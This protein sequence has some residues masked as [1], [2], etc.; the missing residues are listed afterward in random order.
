M[1]NLLKDMK[2]ELEKKFKGHTFHP[3]I[4]KENFCGVSYKIYL[5]I[6]GIKKE[7]ETYFE[8]SDHETMHGISKAKAVRSLEGQYYACNEKFKDQY[9]LI[10]DFLNSQPQLVF[11]GFETEDDDGKK[12]YGWLIHWWSESGKDTEGNSVDGTTVDSK[13]GYKTMGIAEKDAIKELKKFK[14]VTYA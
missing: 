7:L 14:N 6:N 12:I 11:D 10:N 3:R 13:S 1:R 2:K 4:K 5:K 9:E 8:A